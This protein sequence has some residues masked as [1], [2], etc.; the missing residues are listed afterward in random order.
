MLTRNHSFEA[1]GL[2]ALGNPV[3]TVAAFWK[4]KNATNDIRLCDTTSNLLGTCGLKLV[5]DAFVKS[6]FVN[7]YSGTIGAA[8][9]TAFL[10][11]YA[12]AFPGYTGEGKVIGKLT[13]ANGQKVKISLDLNASASWD[14]VPEATPKFV[15]A[16]LT[17][18]VVS[19]KTMVK[20]GY[21][22]GSIAVDAVTLSVVTNTDDAPRAALPVPAFGA[23]QSSGAELQ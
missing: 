8:G 3:S 14:H 7:K 11:F 18:P 10:Y 19:A 2:N 12:D 6:K 23:S 20:Q 16:T 13:L 5:G 4:G 1:I 21:A 17:A 15:S 22:T 9:D